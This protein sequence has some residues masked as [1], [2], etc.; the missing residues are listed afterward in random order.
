MV[1]IAFCQKWLAS[2][3]F[4]LLFCKKYWFCCGFYVFCLM[5]NNVFALGWIGFSQKNISFA[6]FFIGFLRQVLVSRCF[7]LVFCNKLQKVGQ[8]LLWQMFEWLLIEMPFKIKEHLSKS[9]LGKFSSKS[10]LT[11][12][13]IFG[14]IA[15]SSLDKFSANSLFN[16]NSQLKKIDQELPRRL[17]QLFLIKFRFATKAHTIKITKSSLGKFSSNSSLLF[18]QNQR[19]LTQS[20]L[21]KVSPNSLLLFIQNERKLT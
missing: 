12:Y 1:F 3:W 7:L 13:S 19:K 4:S 17:L 6:L 9:S 2:L 11:F 8:E 14:K 16:L 21:D 5:K 20:S 15:K 18:I 10:F